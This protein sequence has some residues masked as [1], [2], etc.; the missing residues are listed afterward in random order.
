MKVIEEFQRIFT[1]VKKL[2]EQKIVQVGIGNSKAT[3]IIKLAKEE[4]IKQT[5]ALLK[6]C[7]VG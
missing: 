5:I 6:S 1:F 4:E 7:E 3:M 2:S